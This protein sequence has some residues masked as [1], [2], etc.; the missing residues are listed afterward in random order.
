MNAPAS[1]ST[2]NALD[3]YQRKTAV[4]A[5][6]PRETALAYVGL[7]LAGEAGEVANQLKKII[8]D[9]A[10]SMTADRKEKL[11]DELGDVLWYCAALARELGLPL[12]Q[13]AQINIDKLS[14]RH[15]KTPQ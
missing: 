11:I 6:Y 5:A 4:F 8:R 14:K 2:A 10:G 7:G 9:D 13:V 1:A 3:E 12:S 15:G